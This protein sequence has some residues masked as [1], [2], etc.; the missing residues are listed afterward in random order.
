MDR[1]L[2]SVNLPRENTRGDGFHT[3]MPEHHRAGRLGGKESP[4]TRQRGVVKKRKHI[5]QGFRT[6]AA[7]DTALWTAMC[8]YLDESRD[9]TTVVWAKAHAEDGGAKTN[10]HEKQN[11]K[12]DNNAE[13]NLKKPTHP[14][15]PPCI[16]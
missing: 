10:D 8:S 13:N 6:A 9:E 4:Q 14:L 2:F 11:K 5:S 7:A 15:A 1:S 3:E 16:E 12:A